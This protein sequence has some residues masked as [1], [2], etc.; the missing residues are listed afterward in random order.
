[1]KTFITSDWHLGETRMQLMQRPFKNREE[2]DLTIIDRFNE[3]VEPEDLVYVVGDAVYS[4][5]DPA[6]SLPL[7]KAMNGRKILI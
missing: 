1:M 7:I 2:N 3:K 6:V 5:A 4:K